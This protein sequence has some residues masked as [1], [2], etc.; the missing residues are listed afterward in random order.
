LVDV[1]GDNVEHLWLLGGTTPVRGEA[2]TLRC[3]RGRRS[4]KRRTGA[5]AM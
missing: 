1:G 2:A 3:R 4:R 5:K